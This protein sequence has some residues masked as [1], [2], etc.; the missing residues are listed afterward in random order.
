MTFSMP[1]KIERSR[2]ERE[3]G[4]PVTAS[5][6][7]KHFQRPIKGSKWEVVHGWHALRHSFCSNCAAAGVEQRLINDWVGHQ[8]AAMVRR[9]RHLFPNKQ[10][11]AIQ[12]TYLA[13]E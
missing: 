2:K 8:T 9:Y 13:A 12:K 11:Q 5:E 10:Q 3:I 4:S 6:L 1:K 7:H